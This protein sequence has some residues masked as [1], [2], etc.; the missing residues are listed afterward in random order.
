MKLLF[1]S[2]EIYLLYLIFNK[3]LAGEEFITTIESVTL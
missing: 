1:I 2:N 3:Q